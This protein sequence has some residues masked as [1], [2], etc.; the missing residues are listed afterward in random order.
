MGPIGHATV[1]KQ[2][3]NNTQKIYWYGIWI[4]HCFGS[5]ILCGLALGLFSPL[6][7]CHKMVLYFPMITKAVKISLLHISCNMFY[8]HKTNA[9]PTQA[10]GTH[11]IPSSFMKTTDSL[12]TWLKKFHVCNIPH[13]LQIIDTNH[14]MVMVNDR[15]F[16][17]N[18]ERVNDTVSPAYII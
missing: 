4:F 1:I 12:T 8:S 5:L 16:H 6:I 10:T 13:L 2:M 15:F 3:M 14:K 7:V 11:N 18:N 9:S 17:E